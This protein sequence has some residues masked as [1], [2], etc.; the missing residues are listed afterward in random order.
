M[1]TPFS[2]MHKSTFILKF[3]VKISELH[4]TF[5]PKGSRKYFCRNDSKKEDIL[6][7]T[8]G[9]RAKSDRYIIRY[10]GKVHVVI[11][12]L[13]TSDMG[14][15]RVGVGSSSSWGSH[16]EFKIKVRGEFQLKGIN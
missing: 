4:L 7:E 6:I 16:Q 13:T 14:W 15:Y 1:E 10:D 12:E 3:K 2:S 11:T 9:N 8:C 5:M